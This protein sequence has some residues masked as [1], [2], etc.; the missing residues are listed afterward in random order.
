MEELELLYL[1]TIEDIK[2]KLLRG[3][4]YHIIKASGLLRHLFL[5]SEPLIHQINRQ[6]RAK[7]LFSIVDHS[8]M[9]MIVDDEPQHRPIVFW[10]NLDPSQIDADLEWVTLGSQEMEAIDGDLSK[11]RL[12]SYTNRLPISVKRWFH[13]ETQE[14]EEISTTPNYYAML[15]NAGIQVMTKQIK[16][17]EFLATHCLSFHQFDY[18]VKDIIK[19]CAHYKGGVHSVNPIDDKDRKILNLDEVMSIA[20]LEASLANLKGISMIAIDGL[21]TL[22]Q[23]I[24]AKIESE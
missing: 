4:R 11:L 9:P 10:R 14:W 12:P 21:E 1:N 8:T 16:L 5:D 7:L 19:T 15:R 22:T 3:D 17:T 13:P 24:S 2:E 6:H 20:G 18:S 23:A